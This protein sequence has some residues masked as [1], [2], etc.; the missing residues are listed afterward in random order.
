MLAMLLNFSKSK[1]WG[2]RIITR[3]L[4]NCSVALLWIDEFKDLRRRHP[5]A[6]WPRQ[7]G[8]TNQKG[9]S[10]SKRMHWEWNSLN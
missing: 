1:F 7:S 8:E 4:S 2:I 9:F 10:K 6:G 5:G 3:N